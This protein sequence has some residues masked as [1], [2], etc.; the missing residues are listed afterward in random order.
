MPEQQPP[1]LAGVQLEQQLQQKQQQQQQQQEVRDWGLPPEAPASPKKVEPKAPW[2]A[3]KPASPGQ[4]MLGPLH[5]LL[6][7]VPAS[8]PALL[9]SSAVL[10]RSCSNSTGS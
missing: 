7:F 9:R 8:K 10:Q 4:S 3:A 1:S 5:Q 2:G 6:H